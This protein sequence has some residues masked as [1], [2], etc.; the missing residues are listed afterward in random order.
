MF[1]PSISPSLFPVWFCSWYDRLGYVD[2]DLFLLA[3]AGL[4]PV[5]TTVYLTGRLQR[6]LSGSVY[7]K[8]VLVFLLIMGLGLMM[9]AAL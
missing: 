1:R 2:L 9:R 6:R 3:V 5:L 4:I 7:R 8:L